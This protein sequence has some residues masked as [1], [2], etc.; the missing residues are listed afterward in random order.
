VCSVKYS[1]DEQ[2]IDNAIPLATMQAAHHQIHVIV[3]P[4]TRVEISTGEHIPC[5]NGERRRDDEA[6][7]SNVDSTLIVS[8]EEWDA[9]R[10]TV[11]NNT[12]IP[13]GV[14]IGTLSAYHVILE[15]KLSS[16]S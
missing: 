14:L 10:N 1:F 13:I 12:R 3:N 6:S 16:V 11:I 8:R 7:G 2:G 4:Q 15:K 9:A 5:A